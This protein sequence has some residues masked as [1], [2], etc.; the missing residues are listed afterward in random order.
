MSSKRDTKSTW[1]ETVINQ[2]LEL[3]DVPLK[4][5]T[6]ETRRKIGCFLN[7]DGC[8]ISLRDECDG[9]DI[10][11]ENNIKGIAELAG[12]TRNQISN[13]ILQSDPTMDFIQQ[14]SARQGS[15]CQFCRYLEQIGR[16]GVLQE[17]GQDILNDC[18]KY[19]MRNVNTKSNTAT[20]NS[21]YPFKC[22]E[23]HRGKL[24]HSI[25]K[26]DKN[27]SEVNADKSNS[28]KI[29]QP[30]SDSK[31]INSNRKVENDADIATS[32]EIKIS[33]VAFEAD[34]VARMTTLFSDRDVSSERME[35]S[36]S[37][38][39]VS[40]ER[41]KT[42]FSDRDVSSERAKTSF[43]DRDVSSE[44]M[45]TSFSNRTV[46]SKRCNQNH[47]DVSLDEVRKTTC[48]HLKHSN[49]VYIKHEGNTED[50]ERK[51]LDIDDCV[52]NDIQSES[53]NRLSEQDHEEWHD[54]LSD[55]SVNEEFQA[56][57]IDDVLTGH[58]HTRYH[59]FICYSVE[60]KNDR[61]FVKDMI[62]ILETERG[63]KLF[64]PGRDDIPGTAENPVTAYI[65][66]KRCGTSV[67]LLSDDFLQSPVCDFQLR[68]THALS[69]AARSNRLI[70]VIINEHVTVPR[71]L[72]Y[73]SMCD[74]SD[75]DMSDWV[76]NRLYSAI[77]KN[78]HI[79]NTNGSNP[80][81]ES[82]KDIPFPVQRRL[83]DCTLN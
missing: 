81:E 35:T 54:F 74:F 50:I 55:D 75:A 64:V 1:L 71:F 80:L 7:S 5:I 77:Q 45:E 28:D 15:V 39:D 53:G 58:D 37:D 82:L 44:R 72:D 13:L 40:S 83:D 2:L 48:K 6:Y 27:T 30:E 67:V 18:R 63:L 10:L 70:P 42:S 57:T 26:N 31:D 29:K 79:V 49:G 17:C 24:P 3:K 46:S 22:C 16:L 20:L 56:I 25:G 12:F 36:F 23:K 52:R 34:N 60:S 8:V 43:S 69:P 38:R 19:K 61:A 21:D 9:Y 59:A 41:A 68:F 62:Q 33:K 4:A 11:V 47:H 65:I 51:I 78:N 14:Y 32:K 73:V 66:E 76:W